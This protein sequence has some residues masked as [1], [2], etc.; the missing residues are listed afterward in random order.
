MKEYKSLEKLEI[1]Q[2]TVFIVENTE[3]RKNEWKDIL[4]KEV[5]IDG[6]KFTIK[7]VESFCIPNIKKGD[8]IGLLV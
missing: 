2:G 7:A 6:K 4:G 3:D 8:K 5:L 1:K